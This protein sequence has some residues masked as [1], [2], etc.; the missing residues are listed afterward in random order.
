M[1]FGEQNSQPCP[2]HESVVECRAE[3]VQAELAAQH[4]AWQ[5]GLTRRRFLVG[6]GA[7]GVSVVGSQLVTTR[8]AYGATPSNPNTVIVMFLRGGADGLRILSPQSASLGVNYLRSVRSA[9]TPGD[10]DVIALD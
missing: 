8:V 7:L 5:S 9:L 1:P 10:A 4:G 3:Q 2:D 6:A